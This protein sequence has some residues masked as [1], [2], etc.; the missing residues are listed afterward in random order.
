MKEIPIVYSEKSFFHRPLFETNFGQSLA[1]RETGQRVEC[2]LRALRLSGFTDINAT[3]VNG[4]PWIEQ[5]H[6]SGYLK[7]LKETSENFD[8]LAREAGFKPGE[9]KAFY[10]TVILPD[11]LDEKAGDYLSFE[12]RLGIFS[13]DP[14][15]PIT[16]DT[17]LAATGSAACAVAGAQLL[18]AGEDA[19]YSLCRPPGH[20]ASKREMGGYCYINNS[21]VAVEVL[22]SG[23]AKKVAILDIDLHHCNGTQDIFYQRGDIVLVSLHGSPE[24]TYPYKSGFAHETGEGEGRGRILNI[25]LPKAT[26]EKVYQEALLC[27]LEKIK[28]FKPD[29]LIVSAGFDTHKKDPFSNFQLSTE[30][31]RVV[32]KTIAGLKIP[33]LSI[34]EGGYELE[35]LGRSVVGY[36]NGLIG[37]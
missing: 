28:S 6:D 15:A 32:G 26:G 21:A 35:V 1:Y 11:S 33:V 16:K 2:I 22:I 12:A 8:I 10:P 23:G 5:V 20:H 25:L 29:F 3:S 19:V 14:F 36:L 9:I 13:D 34:Q 37:L 30:Y 27:G 18:L 4:M 31:Y 24:T 7:F 17:F